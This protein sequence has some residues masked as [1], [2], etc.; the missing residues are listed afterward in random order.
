[1]ADVRMAQVRMR[2]IQGDLE[3]GRAGTASVFGVTIF[4]EV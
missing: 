3:Q 2:E 4:G 1:M